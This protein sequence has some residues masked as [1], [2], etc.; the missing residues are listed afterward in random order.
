MGALKSELKSLVLTLSRDGSTYFTVLELT[1]NSIVRMENSGNSVFQII[2]SFLLSGAKAI[3]NGIFKDFKLQ[4]W[5]GSYWYDIKHSQGVSLDVGLKYEEIG[6]DEFRE[7][8]ENYQTLTKVEF[9]LLRLSA[10]GMDEES[11]SR[12]LRVSLNTVKSH[13]KQVYKK[14]GFKNKSEL[15]LWSERYLVQLIGD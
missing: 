1:E 5:N 8:K 13:R 14:L 9:K 7:I 10:Q 3:S 12:H 6:T 2:D 15:I 4:L 11:I